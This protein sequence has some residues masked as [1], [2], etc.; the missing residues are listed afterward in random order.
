M[1]TVQVRSR[2][3]AFHCSR[4]MLP[5]TKSLGSEMIMIITD[6]YDKQR[7][8][9]HRHTMPGREGGMALRGI[10]IYA[11]SGSR[12]RHGGICHTH[13]MCAP[14]GVKNEGQNAPKWARTLTRLQA[15]VKGK[16]MKQRSKERLPQPHVYMRK[17]RHTKWADIRQKIRWEDRQV[18]EGKWKQGKIRRQGEE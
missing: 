4:S 9:T 11:W 17:Q 3:P 13:A 14:G 1:F 2:F 6:I 15:S 18:K 12:S 5:A 7:H 8:A 16:G 10:G